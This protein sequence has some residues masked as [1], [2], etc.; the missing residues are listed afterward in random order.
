M[1]TSFKIIL[2][3]LMALTAISSMQLKAS[4]ENIV[5]YWEEDENGQLQYICV[6]VSEVSPCLIGCIPP[7]GETG[8]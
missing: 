6:D 3:A 5:C 8:E 2:S 4:E 1:K 7:C